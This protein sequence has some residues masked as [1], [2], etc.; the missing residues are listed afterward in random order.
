MTT[1][2]LNTFQVVSRLEKQS[3]AVIDQHN[4]RSGLW[5][6]QLVLKSTSKRRVLIA[7]THMDSS[8]GKDGERNIKIHP[9]L[10]SSRHSTWSNCSTLLQLV[11]INISDHYTRRASLE[12]PLSG[13]A[14]KQEKGS[15]QEGRE[16]S[17]R[18]KKRQRKK[19]GGEAKREEKGPRS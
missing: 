13:G 10:V 11:L 3:L 1:R 15:S 8:T 19:E 12:T 7:F 17:G 9:V 2:V 14:E 5:C 4:K 16:S 18:Q 6:V